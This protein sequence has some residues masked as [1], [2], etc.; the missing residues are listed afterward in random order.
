MSKNRKGLIKQLDTLSKDIV[1]KRDGNNCQHC[2]KWVEG[3]NRH[4]SHV[5]PVS[6]GNKLR[7]DPLNMKILCYHCHINWWHK[8]PLRAAEWFQETFPERWQYLQEN[9]GTYKFSLQELE[10]LI[11]K[12]KLQLQGD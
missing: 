5:I 10:N 9:E 2:Y 12:Y 7:W 11:V 8:N 1:R 3:S 6:A 4:C